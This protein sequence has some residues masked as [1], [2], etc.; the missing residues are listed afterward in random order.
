MARNL[1]VESAKEQDDVVVARACIFDAAGNILLLKRSG[2]NSRGVGKWECPGGKKKDT[3]TIP[4]AFSR[5]L[6]KETGI[7]ADPIA[8]FEAAPERLILDGKYKGK[9]YKSH[10]AFIRVKDTQ[11]K[12]SYEHDEAAWVS[13]DSVFDYD[14]TED[15]RTALTEFKPI[16][17][18]ASHMEQTG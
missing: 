9:T 13:V 8:H 4:V 15:T 16:I 5:E 2:N 10:F 1:E 12:L 3:E 6:R 17:I 18:F 14:L 11:V 7:H